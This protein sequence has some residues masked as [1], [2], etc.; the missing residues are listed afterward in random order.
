MTD[1]D[2]SG[3]IYVEFA[4]SDTESVRVTRVAWAEWAAGPTIRIQK[5]KGNGGLA[6]GP[7]FPEQLAGSLA[8]ALFD[9]ASRA[10]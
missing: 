4:M 2:S 10:G 6:M 9:V 8:K 3:N 7:E 5:R 1:T